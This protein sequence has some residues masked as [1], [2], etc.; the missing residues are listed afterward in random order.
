MARRFTREVA[1][2]WDLDADVLAD[3]ELLVSELVT[4]AVLHARSPARLTIEHDGRTLRVTVADESDAQPR[5]RDYGADAVTGR[6][7]YLVDRISERWGVD[8]VRD[9]HYG[10]RVWFELPA[11]AASRFR[12]EVRS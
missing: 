1:T 7:L 10:K 11:P 12:K 8:A 2:R 5:L 6:G 9:D 4:N 3:V